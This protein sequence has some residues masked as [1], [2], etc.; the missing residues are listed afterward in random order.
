M[1][2]RQQAQEALMGI[3]RLTEP[4]VIAR[5]G[6]TGYSQL[7]TLLASLG[8]I[9]DSCKFDDDPPEEK[10]PAPKTK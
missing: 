10:P 2:T 4:Q 8:R 6:K 7:T 5:M 3:D 1:T 9:I